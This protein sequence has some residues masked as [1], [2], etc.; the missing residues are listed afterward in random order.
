MMK[1]DCLGA[2]EMWFLHETEELDVMEK[3]VGLEI[4]KTCFCFM[5]MSV[6]LH[7]GV[8]VPST[9]KDQKRLHVSGPME[10]YL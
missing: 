10:L 7:V 3:E 4:F 8:Y 2:I 6:I 1:S 9:Q 5:W